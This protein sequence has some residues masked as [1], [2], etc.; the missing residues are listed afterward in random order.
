[1]G[2][3]DPADCIIRTSLGTRRTARSSPRVLRNRGTGCS[4]QVI[5]QRRIHISTILGR[6]TSLHS[7]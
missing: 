6:K 7:P 4:S 2:A 1:M 3:G 5:K